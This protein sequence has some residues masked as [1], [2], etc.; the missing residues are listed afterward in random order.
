MVTQLLSDLTSPVKIKGSKG[1]ITIIPFETYDLSGFRD[2]L[3]AASIIFD[4]EPN[5]SSDAFI[6]S[7]FSEAETQRK[8]RDAV[9]V[10]QAA[11]TILKASDENPRYALVVTKQDIFATRFNFVFGLANHDLGVGLISTAR[12]TEWHDGISSSQMK[13][14]VLKEAAHEIGH[15]GGLVHCEKETCFMA[16]S[17]TIEKVDKKLPMLCEDCRR[18]LKTNGR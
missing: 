10:I 5:F 12:L 18:K 11:R 17:E 6:T 16:F 9:R 8:Q 2:S 1:Q 14:R 15:L 7:D 13:E 4:L 3:D